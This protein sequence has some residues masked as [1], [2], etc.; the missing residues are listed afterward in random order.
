[1][2]ARIRLP[3]S[4]DLLQPVTAHSVDVASVCD[5]VGR[6]HLPPHVHCH[7][8]AGGLSPVDA[9]D[10]AGP[11]QLPGPGSSLSPPVSSAGGAG[12]VTVSAGCSQS[13]AGHGSAHVVR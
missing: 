11:V 2:A 10:D 12:T 1:M 5:A 6:G 8:A 9:G 4:S 3:G 7:V 13:N